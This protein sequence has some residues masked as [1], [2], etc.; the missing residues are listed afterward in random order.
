VETFNSSI[1]LF[2]LSTFPVLLLEETVSP[3]IKSFFFSL[4][5]KIG[6]SF[7]EII[8]PEDLNGS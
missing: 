2:Q 7:S 1:S 8:L 3:K 5:S 4:I 6:K